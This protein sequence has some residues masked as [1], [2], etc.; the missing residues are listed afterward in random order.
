MR[1]D[2]RDIQR[3][4]RCGPDTRNVINVLRPLLGYVGA[5][6]EL[7]GVESVASATERRGE[8]TGGGGW[9]AD[10]SDGDGGRAERRGLLW[11]T[12]GVSRDEVGAVA[13]MSSRPDGL[14]VAGAVGDHPERRHRIPGEDR[15]ADPVPS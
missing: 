11:A 8:V 13:G 1:I 7:F 10:V 15:L 12:L 14:S 3:A 9:G 2:E 5:L 6:F 4:A